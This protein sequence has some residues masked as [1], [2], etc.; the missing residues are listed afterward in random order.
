MPDFL[1]AALT[2]P[3]RLEKYKRMKITAIAIFLWALTSCA[4]Q[5]PQ[6]ATAP[7]KISGTEAFRLV[8]KSAD[9]V[10]PEGG[11]D[12]RG[13]VILELRIDTEGNV[14]NVDVKAGKPELA[15]AAAAA[16]RQYKFKPY[17]TDGK[18]MEWRVSAIAVFGGRNTPVKLSFQPLKLR[19]SQ[20]VMDANKTRDVQPQYPQ[21][22]LVAR[23]QGDVV[24]GATLSTQGDMTNLMLVSGHPLLAQA[25]IDAV[26]QWKYKPYLLNGDPVEVDTVITVKFHM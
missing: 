21:E 26:K 7:V 15:D 23:I 20:G 13:M 2:S 22:A 8:L 10:Y 24:L 25:A 1:R 14:A 5:N 3:V 4:L 17:L 9:A 11:D 6:P 18:P 12:L 19:V 16:F